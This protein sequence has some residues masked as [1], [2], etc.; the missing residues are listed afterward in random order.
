MAQVETIGR[1]PETFAKLTQPYT[2]LELFVK[3]LGIGEGVDP[4]ALRFDAT[5]VESYGKD[6]RRADKAGVPDIVSCVHSRG[7][8][9]NWS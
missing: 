5:R 1:A 2:R 8:L 9:R 6:R 3:G 7:R 4:S